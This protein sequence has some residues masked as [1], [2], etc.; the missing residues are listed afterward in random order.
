MK[1][2]FMND[3]KEEGTR[4]R[5]QL[6]KTGVLAVVVVALHVAAIGGFF[7]IQGCGTVNKN[8]PRDVRPAP[9]PVMPPKA[10]PQQRSTSRSALRPP[11]P[12]KPAPAYTASQNPKTYIVR[13]GDSL[14]R[15]A[16]RVGVSA[17]ELAEINGIKNPNQIRIGQELVLPAYARGGTTAAPAR[18]KAS[19]P[20][21]ARSKAVASGNVYVVKAGDVLSRI[22]VRHGTTVRELREVN[23]L[24][25]DKI[26][27]GQKLVLPSGATAANTTKSTAKPAPARKVSS[28]PAAPAPKKQA[29]ATVEKKQA[30][31]EPLVVD[32]VVIEDVQQDNGAADEATLESA[33]YY[34]V[35]ADDTFEKISYTFGLLQEDIINANNF[36]P[37]YELKPGEKILIPTGN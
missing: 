27:V 32:E 34:T 13:K 30:P 36:S 7:T 8:E 22:A 12:V 5:R 21:K 29:P 11:V 10:S 3:N 15:I 28:T 24:S 9:S 23:K 33:F 18:K 25:T 20:K 6:V 35:G 1:E 14:S 16:S 31:S 2:Q 19:A 37:E 4:D 26:I 17:R